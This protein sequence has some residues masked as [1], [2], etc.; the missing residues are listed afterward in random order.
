MLQPASAQSLPRANM[1]R[2]PSEL[3]SLI[4]AMRGAGAEFCRLQE[5]AEAAEAKLK[6]ATPAIP[7]VFCSWIE[8]TTLIANGETTTFPRRPCYYTTEG[9]IERDTSLSPDDYAAKRNELLAQIAEAESK[10][11]QALRT[12]HRLAQQEANAASAAFDR[13]EAAVARFKP[14]TAADAAELL[15]I[16]TNPRVNTFSDAH[17]QLILKNIAKALRCGGLR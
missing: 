3:L 12:A 2:A 5:A 17:S 11:P 10:A 14:T 9:A 8:E 15:E 7:G 13:A 6:A 16:V 1:R 4:A